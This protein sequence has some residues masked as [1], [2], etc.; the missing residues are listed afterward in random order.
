MSNLAAMADSQRTLPVLS[1]HGVSLSCSSRSTF[2]PR[3]LHFP[4]LV[5]VLVAAF[6][7]LVS[8]PSLF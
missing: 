1:H 8:R 6:P 3:S 2:L 5:T 4:R 7:E